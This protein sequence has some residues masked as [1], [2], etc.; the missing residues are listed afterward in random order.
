MPEPSTP[1]PRSDEA[2]NLPA[3]QQL[4]TQLPKPNL[5]RKSQ[6]KEPFPARKKD[7]PPAAQTQQVKHN[8]V[9]AC[10]NQ[11]HGGCQRLR[12][13]PSRHRGT[14]SRSTLEK[15]ALPLQSPLYR[16]V[17][18]RQMIQIAPDDSDSVLSASFYLGSEVEGN[19]SSG[20][21]RNSVILGS[22]RWS[23]LLA[24]HSI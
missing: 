14:G 13:T 16:R 10:Q 23:R 18:I 15:Q 4:P 5:F 19:S 24:S 22:S 9:D 11:R 21:Q 7:P 2:V 12:P 6:V 17:Q 20:G 3:S 1:Q 8:P